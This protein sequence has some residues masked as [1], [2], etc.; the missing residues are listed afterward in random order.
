[1][2]FLNS[3]FLIGLTAAA[4]PVIIHLLNRRR[5]RK[6]KFSSLAFLSE[7]ARR[8]MRN[9]SLR[10]LLILVLRTLAVVFIV[11]AFA[12]PTLRGGAFLLA[13]KAPKNVVICLDAS[14]S[15]GV[16]LE[17]GTA[18]TAAKDIAKAVV[19]EAGRQDALNL[20]LFA[21]GASTPLDRGVR[22]KSL[23]K[24]A[25][26]GAKLTAETTSIQRAID[27]A[28]DIIDHSDLSG[29]EIYVISDFRFNADST[30]TGQRKDRRDVRVFFVPVYE[31]EVDN[32]SIDRVLV[33][34]KLLRS[35]EVIRVAVDVTNH[36][37]QSPVSFP[38]EL[39]VGGNRK[40]E[41]VIDLAPSASG[42]VTFPISFTDWGTYQCRASKSHDRLAVDD[43]RYFLLEVSK[44]VPVTLVRGMKRLDE[45]VERASA[46]DEAG[47]AGYFY[48]EKALNP[49]GTAEGE[50]TVTTI[51]ENALTAASLPARG[52][53]VWTDP[54]QMESKRF[55]LLE[56]YVTRGGALMVFL[57]NSDRRLWQDSRF[58]ELVG[59]RA[60][61]ERTHQSR[62]GYTSFQKGHP[63]FSLFNEEELEMLARTRVRRYIAA[64]GVA[65]DSVLAYVGGGDPALW[66]CSRGK[67]KILVF[68]ATPDL[69]DS[70]IPLSP[71]FLPLVHTSVSYLASAGGAQRH[72]DNRVGRQLVFDAPAAALA[73]SQLVIR[74]PDD[75]PVRPLLFETPLGE[76]QAICEHPDKVGFYRLMQDTTAVAEA[77]ANADTR[78]SNIAVRAIPEGDFETASIVKTG[79]DF[80][81][82]LQAARQGRE[83]FGLFILLAAAAL[84]AES[85]LS[86]TA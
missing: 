51:D 6:I 72:R 74:D 60:A 62:T 73:A 69:R 77:V 44:S 35:G 48:L 52:V 19:D 12:R 2:G 36:S 80:L 27:A 9:I 67:G 58:L 43:D 30:L 79:G 37:P 45:G 17:K 68:A 39:V 10:R 15:M 55:N 61:T 4:I 42:T 33:P 1:M 65:P 32:V 21:D 63:V 56:R 57:G 54:Q 8:R 85:L 76:L 47:H 59:M 81:R 16:D 7:I 23:A 64:R 34:R 14:F 41:K 40:A 11:I 5:V 49:R 78:E 24:S 25:I 28:Y 22:N 86:R 75:T 3:I 70:D 38:L 50:F 18:F 20:V 71:M 29:G 66:E 46:L 84:V 82:N 83:I 53:V 31:D 13:G 26:D